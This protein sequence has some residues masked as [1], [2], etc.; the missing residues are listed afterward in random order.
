QMKDFV[1]WW[2]FRKELIVNYKVE[3][4]ELYIFLSDYKE[5]LRITLKKDYRVHIIYEKELEYEREGNTIIL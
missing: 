4:N 5:G 2:T 3:G 1:D